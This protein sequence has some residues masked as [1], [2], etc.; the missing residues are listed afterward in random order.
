LCSKAE[1]G[2]GRVIHQKRRGVSAHHDQKERV[3]PEEGTRRRE[4][5]TPKGWK[6]IQRV[7]S[8]GGGALEEKSQM[9]EGLLKKKN[10]LGQRGHVDR[11][12]D[13]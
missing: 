9:K 2:R 1:K 4:K 12:S 6:D 13:K 5:T 7:P 3:N 10:A 8:K 11:W